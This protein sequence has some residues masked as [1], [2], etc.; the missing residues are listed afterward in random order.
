[1]YVNEKM[2]PVESILGM[3]GRGV[4]KSGFGGVNS[5]IMYLIC[6]KIF[7]ECH[8]VYAPSTTIKNIYKEEEK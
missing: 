4:E 8:S 5:S 3:V 6:C 7:C 1:M 2:I